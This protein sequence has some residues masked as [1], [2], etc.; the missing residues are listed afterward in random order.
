M[1]RRKTIPV[2][3]LLDMANKTLANP[4]ISALE[5][6]ATCTF[7]ETILF[8]TGNYQGFMYLTDEWKNGGECYSREYFRRG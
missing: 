5:K 6:R 1:A 3:M 8:E 2:Q 4:A 7:I